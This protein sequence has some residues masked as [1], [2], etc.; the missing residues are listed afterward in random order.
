M[1]VVAG[2]E[3]RVTMPGHA[4]VTV[5]FD[6]NGQPADVRILERTLDPRIDVESVVAGALHPQDG[7]AHAR[8]RIDVLA[9]PQGV[10]A[11]VRLRLGGTQ[12]CPPVL[13]NRRAVQ[14]MMGAVGREGR[15]VLILYVDQDGV[16]QER[17]VSTSTGVESTDG[18]A[19]GLVGSMRYDPAYFERQPVPARILYEVIF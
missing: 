11:P 17:E 6:L 18:I 19:L 15:V 1:H 16:V 5:A 3:P 14:T 12:Y 7:V 8:L 4:L 10:D 13:R 2:M 9:A